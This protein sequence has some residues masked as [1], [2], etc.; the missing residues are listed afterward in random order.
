MFTIS[1]ICKELKISRATFNNWCKV[2]NF[3]NKDGKYSLEEIKGFVKKNNKLTKRHNKTQ[4]DNLVVPTNYISNT[5]WIDN[6]NK[7]VN[8]V[9]Q[10]K[11]SISDEILISIIILLAKILGDGQAKQ[12]IDYVVQRLNIK[13]EYNLNND[14]VDFIKSLDW[15]YDTFDDLFGLV[16]MSLTNVSKRQIL[17]Q[18][19]TPNWLI[20]EIVED[21]LDNDENWKNKKYADIACGSGNFLISLL[22]HG[23]NFDK[24]Y[25]NEIDTIPYLI[26][27]LNLIILLPKIEVDDILKHLTNSDSLTNY[28]G[29]FGKIDYFIGNPPWGIKIKQRDIYDLFVEHSVGLSHNVYF[30]L[31]ESLV[32]VA[33]HKKTRDTIDK[34]HQIYKIKK[35]NLKFENVNV[36]IITL[37][38]QSKPHHCNNWEHLFLNKDRIDFLKQI[39]SVSSEYL[40]GYFTLG[41]V[42]GDNKR[43]VVDIKTKECH[44]PI[45]TG[46]EVD[47]F[48]LNKPNKWFNLKTLNLWQQVPSDLSVFVKKKIIYNFIGKEHYFALST[49]LAYTL[50]SANIFI[51]TN[52]MD[53]EII[54]AILNSSVVQQYLNYKFNSVKLLKQHIQSIPLPKLNKGDISKLQFLCKNYKHNEEEIDR[55]VSGLYLSSK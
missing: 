9:K 55:I 31:P 51:P 3:I 23:V 46:K 13:T 45:Y 19:Y 54:C 38:L 32:S 44:T 53:I 16:Y 27:I 18:F 14:L 36:P 42:S 30:V 47:K 26:S 28:F 41:L 25:G 22:K 52:K 49:D 4:V 21:I 40:Q 10:R 37:W 17:G 24:I 7:L 5:K 50:N 2:G 48:Y 33:S 35:H 12:K 11:M 20:E 39:E 1:E 8:Y 34:T 6:V 15:G 29:A 43:W